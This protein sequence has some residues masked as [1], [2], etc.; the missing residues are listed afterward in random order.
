MKWKT[1]EGRG[2]GPFQGRAYYTDI[3]LQKMYNYCYSAVLA[4]LAV[5]NEASEEKQAPLSYSQNPR[6][7]ITAATKQV[8]FNFGTH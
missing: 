2:C 1:G 4:N 3:R 6:L 5:Y 7:F 8:Y